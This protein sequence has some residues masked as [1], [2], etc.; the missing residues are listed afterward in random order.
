M[1]EEIACVLLHCHLFITYSTLN[2]LS[3]QLFFRIIKMRR[4]PQQ[5]ATHGNNDFAMIIF[6]SAAGVSHP[7]FQFHK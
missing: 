3:F 2:P 6:F 7:D 4:E 5:P 1:Y